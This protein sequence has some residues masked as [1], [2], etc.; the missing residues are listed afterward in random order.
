MY[1]ARNV[2]FTIILCLFPILGIGQQKILLFVSYEDAYYSEYIVALEGL[3]ASGFDVDVR[4]A[5]ADSSSIYMLPLGT[6]ISETANT[7]NQNSYEQF[8]AQFNN[9]FGSSWDEQLNSTPPFIHLT[10]SILDIESMEGY[11]GMVIAGGTGIL[12]YRLDGEYLEQGTGNRLQSEGHIKQVAEKLQQ[13]GLDALQ[14][15][16][17][18]LAQC[19][20]ASLPVFWKSPFLG[21][22]L[23]KNNSATG[24]PEAETQTILDSFG[25]NYLPNSVAVV[26]SPIADWEYAQNGKSL[27]ITSRD[28]YPQH[29]AYAT[30]IFINTIQSYPSLEHR[31]A[32]KTVLIIH[33][34]EIDENNCNASNRDNDIPCNYGTGTQIPADYR[35]VKGLLEEELTDG[36]KFTVNA[37]D[38]RSVTLPASGEEISNLLMDYDVVVFFKHWS[39]LVNNELQNA[40]VSYAQKGG[41]VLALHHGLYNDFNGIQSKDILIHQLFGAESAMSTWSASLTNYTVLST[42]YGHFVS[43]FGIDYSQFSSEPSSFSGNPV[44]SGSNGFIQ[45]FPSFQI[46]DELYN[47]MRFVD[48]VTFGKGLNEITPLFSNDQTPTNLSHTTG[49]VKRISSLENGDEGRV[50]YM[51]IGERKESFESNTIYRQVVRNAVAW[52]SLAPTQETTSIFEY[53]S[54]RNKSE[55]VVLTSVYPNPF[56]PLTRI[57]L[58]IKESTFLEMNV[59]SITGEKLFLAKRDY[60]TEGEYTVPIDLSDYASGVYIL[61]IR[62][63][64]FR[65]TKKMMLIK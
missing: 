15:G 2:F 43:S 31:N 29:V 53:E 52:L 16:K 4:S 64:T 45:H 33:G 44:K 41:G 39:T 50:A 65:M 54:I 9:L 25:V 13:L 35:H 63:A 38:L 17:P 14:H 30:Q 47:N 10:G 27:L 36:F 24:Y 49:F 8:N 19:H 22:S 5:R 48:G 11:A 34:G 28:W 32:E 55:N 51:Q 60:F 61:E 12:A 62:S 37:W 20:G 42:N 7:L 21:E 56:N 6:T 23:L 57:A 1:K 18:I 58:T 46:F 26:S 40:I 3:K 59:Y